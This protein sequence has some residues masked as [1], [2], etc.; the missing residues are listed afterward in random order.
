M[1][2]A[3]L[4]RGLHLPC[5]HSVSSPGWGLSP[6]PGSSA[7]PGAGKVPLR[8]AHPVD[9]RQQGR[10]LSPGASWSPGE[11]QAPPAAASRGGCRG[12]QEPEASQVTVL[13]ARGPGWC[14]LACAGLCKPGRW[15]R[16]CGVGGDNGRQGPLGGWWQRLC[17][18]R[19][20]GW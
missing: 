5:F 2:R 6:G 1:G 15:G 19:V 17:F 18:P 10:V 12:C 13:T 7:S 11:A 9:P 16:R 14:P 3:Q 20:S 4:G 8:E